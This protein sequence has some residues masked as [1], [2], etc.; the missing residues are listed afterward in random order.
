MSGY[1]LYVQDSNNN[2]KT[3]QKIMVKKGT[4]SVKVTGLKAGRRYH[5]I[6]RSYRKT[7]DG[8]YY[9]PYYNSS[10]S[11]ADSYATPKT[12]VLKATALSKSRIQLKWTRLSYQLQKWIFQICDRVQNQCQGCL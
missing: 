10:L 2:N 8:N 5:L 9:S 12:P 1:A 4:T 3:I 11:T 7:E 6:I